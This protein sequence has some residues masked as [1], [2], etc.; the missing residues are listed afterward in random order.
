MLVLRISA[1]V[2]AVLFRRLSP[3]ISLVTDPLLWWNF[4]F[5]AACDQWYALKLL[6][7]L[8]TSGFAVCDLA[9]QGSLMGL[10]SDWASAC[11]A[12]VF[13]VAKLESLVCFLLHLKVQYDFRCLMLVSFSKVWRTVPLSETC[14]HCSDSSAMCHFLK[15]FEKASL[16]T[17]EVYWDHKQVLKWM[18]LLFRVSL[19]YLTWFL[20]W[21]EQ[22]S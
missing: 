7:L 16:S 22:P 11:S 12:S 4:L 10:C 6:E 19:L 21:V 17:E 18:V 1:W 20:L 8:K 9:S 2:N 15:H 14:L 3:S 5:L 13:V